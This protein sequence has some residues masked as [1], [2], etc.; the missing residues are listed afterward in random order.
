MG[1]RAAESTV[2]I[3]PATPAEKNTIKE[4]NNYFLEDPAEAPSSLMLLRDGTFKAK[5]NQLDGDAIPPYSSISSVSSETIRGVCTSLQ[6]SLTDDVWVKIMRKGKDV[7]SNGMDQKIEF[8]IFYLMT[9]EKPSSPLIACSKMLLQQI[10]AQEHE[11]TVDRQL[12]VCEDFS[13]DFT[14]NG[15]LKLVDIIDGP[16]PVYD[17]WLHISGVKACKLVSLCNS[18]VKLMS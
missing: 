4:I 12:I 17:S 11:Q 9:V 3:A 14:F 2:I 5:V 8:R 15:V 10:C 1:K 7:K 6:P 18:L 13:V 16:E